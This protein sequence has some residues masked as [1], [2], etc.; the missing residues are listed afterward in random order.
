[1]ALVN[2][3]QKKVVMSKKDIIKYQILTHCYINRVTVS[4]SDLECL[5][6]LSSIGPIELTHFCY[7]ASDE[8][9]IFKSEQTVRN[10][11]NKCEKNGLVTKDPD[12]KKII[13]ISSD[14]KVQTEGSI[15]LD[16]KFLGQ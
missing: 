2:Q 5:T 8:H 6:L 10:C 7:E 13:N 4:D 9:A 1:M 16:Y 15:L 12:N 11:I 14:M 3:V